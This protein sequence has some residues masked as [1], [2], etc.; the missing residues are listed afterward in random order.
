MR[1]ARLYAPQQEKD[2]RPAMLTRFVNLKV[3]LASI[4]ALGIFAGGAYAIVR[5]LD[6]P[7]ADGTY[8]A[9]TSGAANRIV[10]WSDRA[11]AGFANTGFDE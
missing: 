4:L 6:N 8:A 9:A 10:D 3:I 11:N 5:S 7:A 1:E 2:W